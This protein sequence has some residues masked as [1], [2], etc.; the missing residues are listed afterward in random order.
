MVRLHYGPF[1]SQAS[2]VHSRCSNSNNN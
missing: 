1:H 2:P